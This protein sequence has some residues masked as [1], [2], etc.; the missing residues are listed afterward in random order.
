MKDHYYVKWLDVNGATHYG[1]YAYDQG[2]YKDV[3]KGHV[4]VEDAILP[5]Y[6]VVDKK[7]LVD[8]PCTFDGEF[9]IFVRAEFDK[10]QKV[11]DGLGGKVAVG[12]MFS[13]PVGDGCACYVI[14]KVTK[15]T[16]DVEWRGFNLDRWQDHYFGLGRKRVSV[17]EIRRYV[18]VPVFGGLK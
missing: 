7:I 2:S 16:C 1:I 8:L 13:L 4:V 9:D 14:T 10:A 18:H 17:S 11:S 15:A 3:P 5:V 12:S 6:H